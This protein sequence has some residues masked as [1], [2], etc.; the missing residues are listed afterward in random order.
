MHILAG[1]DRPTAGGVEIEGTSITELNDT[2]LT[3]LSAIG[4]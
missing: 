4:G 1:L 2:E 3:K